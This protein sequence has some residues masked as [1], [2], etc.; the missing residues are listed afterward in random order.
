MKNNSRLL[1][2]L[3][4][5]GFVAPLQLP[6]QEMLLPLEGMLPEDSRGSTTDMAAKAGVKAAGDVFFDDFS[7]FPG[8]PD[9]NKWVNGGTYIN[10]QFS[11][12]PI[13]VGIATLDALDRHG[14][15]RLHD[16]SKSFRSDTLTSKPIN[17]TGKS[18]LQFSYYAEPGGLADKPESSD[19][20]ILQFFNPADTLWVTV[21]SI[22]GAVGTGFK[23]R[24]LAISDVDYIRA[25]FRFRFINTVTLSTVAD[26]PSKT[27]NSDIWNLDYILLR[28]VSPIADTFWNDLVFRKLPSSLFKEYTTI[29]WKHYSSVL[30]TKLIDYVPVHITNYFSDGSLST[31]VRFYYEDVANP[32]NNSGDIDRLNNV[33]YN[34]PPYASYRLG[35]STDNL[36]KFEEIASA[37]TGNPSQL[38]VKLRLEI[39]DFTDDGQ[40]GNNEAVFIQKLG[41]QYAYDDGSPEAGYGFRPSS[42]LVSFALRYDAYAA[43][44]LHGLHVYFNPRAIDPVEP[45]YFKIVA[46]AEN[47]GSHLPADTLGSAEYSFDENSGYGWK[48]F[49]FKSPISVSGKYFVG[50]RFENPKYLN[51]GADMNNRNHRTDSTKRNLYI[52]TTGTWTESSV[53]EAIMVRPVFGAQ[54][55]ALPRV[56]VPDKLDVYPNPAAGSV[57]VRLPNGVP[58]G[59]ATLVISDF[60]GRAVHSVAIADGDEVDLSTLSGGLHV[61]YVTLAD[62]TRYTTKLLIRQ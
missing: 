47:A 50:M 44:M 55:L 52:N 34:P 45:E 25:G 26:N 23:L 21:E 42:S 38:N 48:F 22:T 46:W 33:Y 18:N 13:S 1:V 53:A 35:N 19:S 9:T 36:N 62:G 4:L 59:P 28:E 43:D 54:P 57:R 3:V 61:V 12:L 15:M 29:P 2:F 11:A 7:Q 16:G 14:K 49:P 30:A 58:S 56:A 40:M 41:N 10:N 32:G 6:G 31:K 17:L 39:N 5:F 37:V 20:L 24:T 60:T 8:T 51:I 27:G